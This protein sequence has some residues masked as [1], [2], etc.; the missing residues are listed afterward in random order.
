MAREARS[1]PDQRRHRMRRVWVTWGA[2]LALLAGGCDAI[3][4]SDITQ[5]DAKTRVRPEPA[6]ANC[7]FG[8]DA[9]ESGLDRDRDGELTTRRSPPPTTSATPPCPRSAPARGPSPTARTARWG[10][11]RC[12]PAWTRTAT[13]SSTT[14]RCPPPSMSAPPRWP[15][16][17]CARGR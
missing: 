3:D 15:T 4:L 16:C 7:E 13:G 17:S 1:G 2:L 8:G 9:V 12:S 14:R 5:R 10:D 11:R 6:G